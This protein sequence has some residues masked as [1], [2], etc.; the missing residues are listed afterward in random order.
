M[1]CP[2]HTQWLKI[3]DFLLYI[4]KA[5]DVKEFCSHTINRINTLLPFDKA[6]LYI[7][8]NNDEIHDVVL[9][10][11]EKRWNDDYLSYY[12]KIENSR[13]SIFKKSQYSIHQAKASVCDWTNHEKNE[14][15][16]NYVRPQRLKYSLG[17]TLYADTYGKGIFCFDRTS[18][19]RY[20]DEEIESVRIIQPHMQNLLNNL[21]VFTLK[22]KSNINPKLLI[23]LTKREC[24][25]AEILCSGLTPV[26]I[27]KKLFISLSTTNR[28][29]ANIHQKLNVSNRQELL[30]TL[31]TNKDS[32]FNKYQNN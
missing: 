28:H 12:S 1:I 4:E 8:N 9:F 10:G 20:K 14:F 6:R 22:N 31:F 3:H 21:F 19:T 7:I 13:Y 18:S 32:F 17:I 27:S 26:N 23:P 29:I 11:V 16:I 15:V 5:R 24:E 25:I 30:V 2:N